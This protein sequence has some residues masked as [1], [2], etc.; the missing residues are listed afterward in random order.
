M[1]VRLC[2]NIVSHSVDVFHYIER[3]VPLVTSPMLDIEDF[4][5]HDQLIFQAMTSHTVIICRFPMWL[6]KRALGIK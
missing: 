5:T 6:E 4:S 2:G 1:F 3:T